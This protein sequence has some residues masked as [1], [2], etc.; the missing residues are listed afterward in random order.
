VIV[1]RILRGR[2]Y[3]LKFDSWGKKEGE[4]IEA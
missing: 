4:R 1:E 3:C 2:F